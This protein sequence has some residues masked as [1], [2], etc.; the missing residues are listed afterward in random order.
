[1]GDG[2]GTKAWSA[3][4]LRSGSNIKNQSLVLVL[5]AV[6]SGLGWYSSVWSITSLRVLPMDGSRIEVDT[7]S[8]CWL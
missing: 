7:K 1:V 2:E 4:F 6:S 5:R 8:C 3:S